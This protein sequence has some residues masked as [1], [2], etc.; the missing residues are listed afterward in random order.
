MKGK[1]SEK[2]L[3]LLCVRATQELCEYC[4]D[5]S[6]EL[7]G[8]WRHE[9]KVGPTRVSVKCQ[10]GFLNRFLFANEQTD[11]QRLKTS[12][13]RDIDK[14]IA[15]GRIID[16]HWAD[17]CNYMIERINAEFGV[18]AEAEDEGQE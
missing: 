14:A 12:L 4:A 6:W 2:E 8:G 11:L 15:S 16:K 3:R 1:S 18:A 5:P 13:Q 17:F 7:V 9:R 10:A